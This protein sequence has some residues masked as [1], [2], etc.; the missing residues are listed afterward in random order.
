MT[1]S[2]SGESHKVCTE[3]ESSTLA[4]RHTDGGGDQV[5]YGEHGS[6]NEGQ[7]GDFVEGE[8]V[9]GDEHSGTSDYET[10]NQILD[11]TVD[12]FRDVHCSYIHT[13]ENFSLGCGKFI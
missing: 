5:E 13:L 2:H 8:L 10:F 9:T 12:N 1:L 3:T 11:S 6:G 7:C 4:S